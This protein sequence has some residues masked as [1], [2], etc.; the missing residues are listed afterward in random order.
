MR[1]ALPGWL[2]VLFSTVELVPPGNTTVILIL[3]YCSVTAVMKG[4]GMKATSLTEK[5]KT[6]QELQTKMG[7][8]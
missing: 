7:F 2:W 6:E 8:E 1:Q 4:P 3:R 5:Q